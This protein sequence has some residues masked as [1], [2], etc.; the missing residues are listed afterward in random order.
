MLFSFLISVECFIRQISGATECDTICTMHCKSWDGKKTDETNFEENLVSSLLVVVAE[1]SVGNK[2]KSAYI[3]IASM[4]I[5]F[6]G[7]FFNQCT[8]RPH[9]FNNLPPISIHKIM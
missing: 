4:G 8:L 5:N 6:G 9:N 3:A 2:K 7:F 1:Y